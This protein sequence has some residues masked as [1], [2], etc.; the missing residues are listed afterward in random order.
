[1]STCDDQTVPKPATG[2][3][4]VRNA[5]VA[6]DVWL[7]AL[8]KAETEGETA[9]DAVT[10]GLRM[11]AAEPLPSA[12]DFTFANWPEAADWHAKRPAA[13]AA[14]ESELSAATGFLDPEWLAIAVWLASTHHQGDPAQQKRV[15]TGHILR[16]AMSG[17]Y[18]DAGGW[19][20]RYRDSRHL[21]ETVQTILGQHLPLAEA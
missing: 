18:A 15:I 10:R 3:T 21:S 12:Y 13:F 19:R 1:M 17:D 6:D 11:Y 2:K 8:A 9:S 14:L 4:P 16:R 20:D 7:P 5:R